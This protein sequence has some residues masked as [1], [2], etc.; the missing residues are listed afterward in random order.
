[1]TDVTVYGK[2]DCTDT[3]RSRALLDVE[4]VAYRF[5]DVLADDDA[6][7][8]ARE[9]SGVSS[10]PVI[11]VPSGRVLVEPSDEELLVALGERA[12]LAG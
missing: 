9:L 2:Q 11:V 7:E 3:L 1:M 4:G 5:V 10:V 8:R 6:R 12:P